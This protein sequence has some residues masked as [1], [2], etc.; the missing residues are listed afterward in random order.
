MNLRVTSCCIVRDAIFLLF[1][2]M[3]S[4]SSLCM[5]AKAAV[6]AP[7]LKWAYGGC[8]S[9][10]C[11]TGWY[12]SPAIADLDGNGTMEVIASAYS[13]VALQGATGDVLWRVDS[14]KDRS[15]APGY[16]H[17]TWPGIWIKDVDGD[18]SLD[19][20]TAHS[21]GYVSVYDNRGYFKPGWPKHPTENE[22]RGLVVSDID[23]D[24]SEEIVVTGA[25][26]GKTNTWVFEHTGALRSGWPQLSNNT[27][28][29]YGVYNDN[30]WVA[31]LDND[32]QEEIVVPSDVT[33][34]CVY[35]PNGN[36]LS[37]SSL[38]GNKKWGAVGTWENLSTE[39]RGWGQ[40]NGIRSESYRSNFAHG[41][42]VIADVDGDGTKEV[43][44]TG[45]MY[46][47][48]VGHP[49]GKYTS[50]F[51]FNADRSRFKKG[52]WNWEQAPLNTGIPLSES[53]QQ[54][55]NCQPNPVVVDLDG[56]YQKEILFASYDGKMHSFWLDKT[57]HHNWPYSVYKSG[58]GFYRFASEPVVADLDQDG[59]SEV[60][61]TS[62][63]EKTTTGMRL[64][65]LH[66]L[67]CRG[68]VLFEQNLPIPKSA[69]LHSNGALPAP[70]IANIDADS[71][72]E[73]VINTI[74]SGFIAYDLPGSAGAK[75]QWQSGRNRGGH[76]RQQTGI[77][78]L[79][80]LL[81][82]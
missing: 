20:I 28:F 41:A 18:N 7:V 22:I 78:P 15:S 59:C 79:M 38:Y 31:D 3:L 66:I 45:N 57:E 52:S 80:F 54:I 69:N 74:H 33:T 53:Y 14:G 44:V 82:N 56:D 26:N 55:E 25:T 63:V 29:A 67:D 8:Y 40:C 76:L 10:W 21:G 19:I 24:G 68:N 72:Y 6:K 11:E 43:I 49:P 16:S 5:N 58:E 35:Q 13:V 51:I 62:W 61:F 50:L 48:A 60:I 77:V 9:S 73:L 39:I 36:Q 23:K 65:K 27:G 37:A 64:G 1:L 34:L 2:T 47:C 12:S 32:G 30:A 17:R 71:D 75:I 42:S 70:S 81:L 46:N 4:A